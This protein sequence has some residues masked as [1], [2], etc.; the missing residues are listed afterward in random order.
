M[1]TKPNL[2]SQGQGCLL[3]PILSCRS[4][5]QSVPPT[6]VLDLCRMPPPQELVQRLQDFHSDQAEKNQNQSLAQLYSLYFFKKRTQ[7]M[8]KA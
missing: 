7:H 6:Q 3:Q 5:V 4:P 8:Y 2:H 1:T